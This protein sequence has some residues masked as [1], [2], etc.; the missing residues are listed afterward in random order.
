[1]RDLGAPSPRHADAWEALLA[2]AIAIGYTDRP[3]MS[4]PRSYSGYSGARPY[5][6][7]S[8]GYETVVSGV[9]RL[10]E[11]GVLLHDKKPRGRRGFQS[12][13]KIARFAEDAPDL[14]RIRHREPLV[15]RGAD[16][17][18]I[19]YQ[20]TDLT[21]RLRRGLAEL[22]EMSS[23]IRVAFPSNVVPFPGSETYLTNTELHQVFTR[24]F[25]L[26][27]RL[28]GDYQ[29]T[30]KAMR[31]QLLI[32]G[33]QTVELDFGELHIRLLASERSIDFGDADPYAIPGLQRAEAKPAINI[34]LNAPTEKSAVL[35]LAER[36]G[37][38]GAR[39][40]AREC[41]DAA[42]LYHHRFADAFG[43]GEGLRLMRR[44]AD[45]AEAIV[46]RLGADGI[47]CLPIH[48]SFLVPVENEAILDAA[49]RE[50]Y[51]GKV[52]Q[53]PVVKRAA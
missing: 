18:L 35:A 15:L 28:Y 49:M 21:R 52:G 4:Y 2:G 9:D 47:P 50:I 6:P 16:K 51:R 31:G 40:R 17:Q 34:S 1:M 39:Q 19:A 45:I 14:A 20:D 30:P 13:F 3:F 27:G 53:N 11:A 22:N 41:I 8:C 42:K 25:D 37:G 5:L 36:F 44:D 7:R 33:K 29:N 23:D 10:E 26:H 12:R 32:N 48:D 43:R 24:S 46:R 38:S